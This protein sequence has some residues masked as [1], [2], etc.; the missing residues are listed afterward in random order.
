MPYIRYIYIVYIYFSFSWTNCI[1]IFV[2]VRECGSGGLAFGRNIV[3]AV[4]LLQVGAVVRE[5]FVFMGFSD[6]E[7]SLADIDVEGQFLLLDISH[8]LNWVSS[9]KLSRG[10]QS[11]WGHNRVGS[12]DGASLQ[13]STLQN[14]AFE[15]NQDLIVDDGRVNGAASL[16]VYV[17]SNID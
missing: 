4:G 1:L 8:V 5:K 17:I 10:N 7:G 11:A 16:D 3:S 13:L 2:F 15:S 9:P 6:V 12:N 14:N